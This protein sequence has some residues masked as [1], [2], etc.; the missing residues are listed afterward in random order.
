MSLEELSFWTASF[1]EL[2]IEREKRSKEQSKW[3]K[4]R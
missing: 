4:R 3:Q 1:H 2:D